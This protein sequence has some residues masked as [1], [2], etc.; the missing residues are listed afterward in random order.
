MINAKTDTKCKE[1]HYLI[2]QARK[3]KP[4]KSAENKVDTQSQSKENFFLQKL[5]T[6]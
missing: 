5:M 3:E 1:G 6:Y 2:G 4:L